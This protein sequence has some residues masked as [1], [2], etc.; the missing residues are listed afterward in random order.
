MDMEDDVSEELELIAPLLASVPEKAC[1]SIR[2]TATS[3]AS[4]AN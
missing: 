1:P 2:H 3:K 4:T